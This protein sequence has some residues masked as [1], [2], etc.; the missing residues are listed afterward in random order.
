MSQILFLAAKEIIKRAVSTDPDDEDGSP[1]L[2]TPDDHLDDS[3]PVADEIFSSWALFILL[4]LLSSALWSSYFLQ[5]RRIK[6][7]HE[8][9]LSIFYGMIVGLMIRISP[10]HYIQDAVKFKSS[11]FFNPNHLKFRI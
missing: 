3:D 2:T 8:T 1:D 7:V 5:Q 6:A 4:F 9:V 11:Y 10:G